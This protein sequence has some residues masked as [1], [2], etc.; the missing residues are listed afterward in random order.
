MADIKTILRELSVIF[1][2]IIAKYKISI[3]ELNSAAFIILIRQYCKNI[4]ECNSEL[5]KIE[6]IIDITDYESIMGNG[7]KLGELLYEKIKF[8]G[9][10]I[11]VGSKVKSTYPFDIMIDNT[12]IERSFKKSL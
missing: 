11:W 6:R 4:D 10:I 8:E 1:G 7:V 3:G 12:G 5:E 2:F 9:D